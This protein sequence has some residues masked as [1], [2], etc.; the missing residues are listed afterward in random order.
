MITD[1]SY[2]SAYYQCY[3]L[4]GLLLDNT[5][6]NS[7]TYQSRLDYMIDGFRIGVKQMRPN[8]TALIKIESNKAYGSAI[9][10]N[11]P[12]N[13]TLIYLVKLIFIN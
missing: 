8:E 2:F 10:G 9:S 13:S 7:C 12:S 3:F 4:N 5:Y 6:S 11:V 1:S